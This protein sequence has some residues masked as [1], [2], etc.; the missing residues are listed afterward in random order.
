[1]LEHMKNYEALFAKFARALR[2][3]GKLMVHVF[4]HKEMPYH[5]EEGWMTRHF[6]TGGTMPSRDLFL[7]FQ[8]DLKVQGHWWHSGKNYQKTLEVGRIL[9]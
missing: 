5:F 1:M 7:Y 6:F 4:G 8:N 2:P 3:G 9:G